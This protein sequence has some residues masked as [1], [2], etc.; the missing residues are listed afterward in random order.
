MEIPNLE[1]IMASGEPALKIRSQGPHH[2]SEKAH[3]FRVT[4]VTRLQI[5]SQD[6]YQN[7]A[8]EIVHYC[9]WSTYL[10]SRVF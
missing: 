2:H 6:A 4:I 5:P 8:S 9:S 1:T 7:D 3:A 10:R